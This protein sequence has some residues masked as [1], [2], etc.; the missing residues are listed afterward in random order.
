KPSPLRGL[1]DGRCI[2]AG[3]AHTS[4]D[5]R[6]RSPA[7]RK[8]PHQYFA[9]SGQKMSE[10]GGT[11]VSF[12]SAHPLFEGAL[13]DAAKRVRTVNPQECRSSALP[14]R[15][16]KQRATRAISAYRHI[17]FASLICLGVLH[18]GW[19]SRGLATRMHPQ[20]ALDVATFKRLRS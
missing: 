16:Y 1:C 9:L 17:A 5:L 2:Q 8:T 11:L 13:A 4:A 20:R 6:L 10:L 3:V 18:S 15:D 14:W 7:R 12:P 19:S